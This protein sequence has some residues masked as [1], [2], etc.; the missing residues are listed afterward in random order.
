MSNGIKIVALVMGMS[1]RSEFRDIYARFLNAGH[2]IQEIGCLDDQPSIPQSTSPANTVGEEIHTILP[3]GESIRLPKNFIEKAGLKIISKLRSSNTDLIIAMCTSKFETWEEQ[4]VITA[5]EAINS[6]ARSR[7]QGN[8]IGVLVPLES[9]LSQAKMKW[10]AAGFEAE[11]VVLRPSDS[12]SR[13]LRS[14]RTL[15]GS[16]INNFVFDCMSYEPTCLGDIEICGDEVAI[17]AKNCI[18]DHSK[19][20]ISKRF[21][22]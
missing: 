6:V 13:A 14:I 18:F 4:S 8:R 11:T 20:Q 19:T 21:S 15:R 12:T 3:H 1:P 9:Q 22:M 17:F 5:F 10:E 7:F 16:G 2:Q